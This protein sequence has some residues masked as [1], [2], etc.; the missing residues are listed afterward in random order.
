[1]RQII[2]G[3][4]IITFLVYEPEGLAKM[5]RNLKDKCKLWPFSY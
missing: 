5:W 2:F 3:V 1:V 4:I